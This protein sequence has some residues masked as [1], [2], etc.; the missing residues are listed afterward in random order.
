[1]SHI[2]TDSEIRRLSDRGSY[3]KG[4]EYFHRGCVVSLDAA[5]EQV[6]ATVR[7]GEDY[8]VRLSSGEGVLDYD[9][10]CPIG[11]EG[12]F[13]KHCV[14]AALA[15]LNHDAGSRN[16]ELTLADAAKIL[17]DEDKQTLIRVLIE[18]AKDDQLLRERVLLHAAKL[19]GPQCASDAAWR[20]FQKAVRIDGYINYHEAASWA[21]DVGNAIDN[22][23]QLLDDGSADVVIGLCESALQR[24]GTVVDG[25]DDSDGCIGELHERLASLHLKAC[26]MA[27]PDPVALAGR[28]LD[29]E[30]NNDLDLFLGAVTRYSEVL[31]AEGIAHYRKLAEAEWE[32]SSDSDNGTTPFPI[33]YIMESL[34]RISG[35]TEEIVAVLSRDLTHA[36]DYLRIAE[37]YR[38]ADQRDQAL[39]WAEKGLKAFPVRTDSRLREFAADE[40]H[41]LQRHEDA[42][43]LMWSEFS[44]R[45]YLD[46]Y[47]ALE[48]HAK[49]AGT[50]PAWR[51]QALDQFRESIARTNSDH[52]TLVE[53]FL[54][55]HDIDAAWRQAQ[56]GGC[57]DSLWLQLADVRAKE[58]PA[59]AVPIYL[60]RAEDGV[61]LGGGNYDG[62]VDLLVKAAAAMKRLERSAEFV[63][64]LEVMRAKYK[65]KR[66]FTKA[67][68]QRRKFLYL[69]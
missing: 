25:I 65:S 2:L 1:V 69:A 56:Q 15:W 59:D 39:M 41:R 26:Q 50:W 8:T 11:S 3:E 13:C 30:M 34:A 35:S 42:V 37:V 21:H 27:H 55:E 53:V 6:R 58:H 49:R 40:Y 23:Q 24:L 66:N 61:R 18:W 31:G 4:L 63:Q 9:C 68:E 47:R 57:S 46:T 52:S 62:S 54:H 67:V 29:I 45:P 28:L 33:R 14:A 22:F 48:K 12:E 36:Y 16:K 51:E 5:E 44:E 7:G 19:S 20:T 38:D 64:M 60:K 10:D 43:I 32:K 17:Q